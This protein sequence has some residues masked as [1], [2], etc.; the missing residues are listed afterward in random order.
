MLKALIF[1]LKNSNQ[2]R[3]RFYKFLK[4]FNT[5]PETLIKLIDK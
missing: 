3:F 1:T 4:L 2:N 5:F